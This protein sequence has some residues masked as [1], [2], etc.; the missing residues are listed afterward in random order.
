MNDR[1]ILQLSHQ[2]GI[3]LVERTRDPSPLVRCEVV[4]ALRSLVL[5]CEPQMVE[6][7]HLCYRIIFRSLRTAPAKSNPTVAAITNSDR[8]R[9]GSFYFSIVLLEAF[10]YVFH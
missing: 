2:V 9:T 3:R 5:Q 10:I 1:T 6:Q 7:A 4:V 8:P